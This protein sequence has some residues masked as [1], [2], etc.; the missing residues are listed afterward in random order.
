MPFLLIVAMLSQARSLGGIRLIESEFVGILTQ[1]FV[2]L[3]AVGSI[4]VGKFG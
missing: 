4:P 2:G 1:P 3:Y